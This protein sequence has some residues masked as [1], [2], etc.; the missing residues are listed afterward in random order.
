LEFSAEAGGKRM[1]KG[2]DKNPQILVKFSKFRDCLRG[3]E[4]K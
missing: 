3:G 1:E 4:R 2:I